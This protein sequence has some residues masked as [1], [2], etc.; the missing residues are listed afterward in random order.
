[1][2]DTNKIYIDIHSL[3]DIRQGLLIELMG[4]EQAVEFVNTDEYNFRENDTFKVDMNKYQELL[5]SGNIIVLRNSTIS[6][7]E[8]VIQSKIPSLE[9]HNIYNHTHRPPELVVNIYPFTLDSYHVKLLQNGIFVKFGSNI[10][11]SIVSNPI[12]DYS[13]Y[14]LKNSNFV[15]FFSYFP[16]L[17]LDKHSKALSNKDPLSTTFYFPA[18]SYTEITNEDMKGIKELGFKDIFSYTEYLLSSSIR[19]TFLPIFMY[20]NTITATAIANKNK[21]DITKPI[22]VKTNQ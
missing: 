9:R 12:E 10:Q 18:M 8:T 4:L 22:S 1:M 15:Y 14:L 11:V 19:I 3:L 7:L 21:V 17:W 6:Y 16:N 13:P 20:T 5:N 2:N